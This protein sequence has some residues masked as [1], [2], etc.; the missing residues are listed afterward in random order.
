VASET[1][2]AIQMMGKKRIINFTPTG[3]QP[4]RQNS[5]APLSPSEIVEEV[6]FAF[7]LGITVVHL[8]ARDEDFLN[9]WR[10]DVYKD[11]IDGVRKHCPG[12][13][14]CVSLTGRH[15]PEFEKRSAV[16]E[17]MPD[18]GS[19]TMSSLNFPKAASI[20]E[21]DMIIQLIERMDKYG[22]VPEI[23]CFDSGMLNYTNY[24]I[25]K[26]ILKGPHYINVILGNLYNGQSDLST[27]ASILVNKPQDSVMC[28]G[29]I[30]K[31]QM[32]ANMLGLLYADGVRIGLEDNLY[33]KDKDLA[34]NGKLLQRLR[35]IMYDLDLEVMSPKEFVSL[36]YANKI[37]PSRKK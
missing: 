10:V 19:L 17:L 36:G 29:G 3:T 30:G 12:L 18:M 5:N 14:V 37:N 11:I 9:T 34:T 1:K 16:L 31:D 27:V 26:G 25:K 20:N 8:H 4:T 21:P 35:R 32:K 24:L 6:H 22:V 23:E 15:F 28:I 2:E 13:P 33:Y 7:E